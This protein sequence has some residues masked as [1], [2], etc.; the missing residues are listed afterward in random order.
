MCLNDVGNGCAIDAIGYYRGGGCYWH[1]ELPATTNGQ[2]GQAT[3]TGINIYFLNQRVGVAKERA[4]VVDCSGCR[5]GDADDDESGTRAEA[6]G[7]SGFVA[8]DKE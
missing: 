5:L 1:S 6:G 8:D 2:T 3:A 7:G 4:Q